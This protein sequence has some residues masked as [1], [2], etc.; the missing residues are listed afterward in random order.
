MNINK[1]TAILVAGMHRSGTSALAGAL[2]K[3]GI[4]LGT[5]LLEPG[6]D[7]PKGYWEHSDAV[8]I[9]ER[10]LAALDRRWDD[11]RPLPNEWLSSDAAQRASLEIK[12][13]IARDFS[14]KG[15]WAI[16]DPRICRFLPLW[17]Q[18]LKEFGIRPVVIFVARRPSEVAASI[19]KRNHWA[20][21]IGELLWLQHTFEA[22]VSS[23]DLERA[24]LLY[25]DLIADPIDTV[26]RTLAR[27]SIQV[28]SLSASDCED[29]KK[30]VDVAE[31]HHL[32]DE[33]DRHGSL[34]SAIA[35]EAYDA[36]VEIARGKDSWA[37]LVKCEKSFD[38]EWSKCSAMATALA[39]MAHKMSM[40]ERS[41]RIEA[42]EVSSKLNAQIRWSEN[43][44]KDMQT[45]RGDYDRG[46]HDMQAL[47]GDYDRVVHDMQVLRGDYDR[48]AQEL[49]LSRIHSIE[50][51]SGVERL[52]EQVKMSTEERRLE[53]I[54]YAEQQRVAR[55]SLMQA[56]AKVSS[57]TKTVLNIENSL[58]WKVTRPLRALARAIRS[59]S[60]RT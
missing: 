33:I 54:M 55:E 20:A 27:V 56:N 53:A 16:K 31:R 47:R 18:G 17:L 48:V 30:F 9:H 60:R 50:L 11:I 41:A 37:S 10:L 2:N 34:M 13:L 28:P 29:L 23:R 5:R 46:V 40:G 44:V 52:R 8:D 59:A 58:S 3:V 49:H 42:I 21:D 14:D 4:S 45:L 12:E 32:H 1:K 35:T 43:A 15:L 6:E 26:S 39:A 51:E 24:A 25:D 22:E 38:V 19:E 7:N 57:L 36:L